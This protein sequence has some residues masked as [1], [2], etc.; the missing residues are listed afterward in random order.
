M[1]KTSLDG[2]LGGGSNRFYCALELLWNLRKK[3]LFKLE[4]KNIIQTNGKKKTQYN[5]KFL[6]GY[7]DSVPR[8][9][10]SIPHMVRVKEED[11]KESDDENQRLLTLLEEIL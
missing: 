1:S 8:I 2:R 5:V 3:L 9:L 10:E 11:E 7:Y 6:P 4:E